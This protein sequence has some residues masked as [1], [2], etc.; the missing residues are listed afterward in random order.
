[1]TAAIVVALTIYAFTTETDF[2]FLGGTLFVASAVICVCSIYVFIWPSRALAFV[3]GGLGTI[4]MGFYLI[5]D[6]QKIAGEHN[7]KYL[8]DDY[9]LA[10][11]NLYMDIIQMFLY[12]LQALGKK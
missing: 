8:I 6:A 2:T 3:L 5:Y 7:R 10:S 12:I 4:A 9:V 11:M 1:M